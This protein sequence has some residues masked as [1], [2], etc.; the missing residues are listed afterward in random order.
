MV[1]K[2]TFKTL[3]NKHKG[4]CLIFHST[5]LLVYSRALVS[6]INEPQRI[7]ESIFKNYHMGALVELKS[8]NSKLEH[9]EK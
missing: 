7:P 3:K 8:K 4:K 1:L 2:M 9:L 6:S 5:F